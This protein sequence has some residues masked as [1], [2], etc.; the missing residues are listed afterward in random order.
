MCVFNHVPAGKAIATLYGDVNSEAKGSPNDQWK[1][2][3]MSLEA[4]NQKASAVET[5]SK[6]YITVMK[7]VVDT[8]SMGW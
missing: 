3:N 1:I 2:W 6:F 4:N 8:P 7:C 5:I